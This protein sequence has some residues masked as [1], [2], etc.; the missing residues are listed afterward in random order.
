LLFKVVMAPSFSDDG[1][2]GFCE[3]AVA[4][5]ALLP[6]PNEGA[7]ITLG[8]LKFGVLNKLNTSI[9]NCVWTFS[10]TLMFLSSEKSIT[11]WFGPKN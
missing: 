7:A 3:S 4:L 11:L 10:V 6:A 2:F 9:R 1:F 5:E 8:A